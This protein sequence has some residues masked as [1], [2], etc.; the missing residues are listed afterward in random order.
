MLREA[1]TS[2]IIWNFQ[3]IYKASIEF[4]NTLPIDIFT[5]IIASDDLN[6]QFEYQLV[7]IV[8]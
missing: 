1:T 7:E 2:L 4:I 5:Q 3:D 6:I 8:S